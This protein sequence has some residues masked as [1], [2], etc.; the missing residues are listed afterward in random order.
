V[1]LR[2][3]DTVDEARALSGLLSDYVT[4]VTSEFEAATGVPVDPVGLIA[5]TLDSLETCVPPNGRTFVAEDDEGMILGMTFLRPSG[6]EGMEIKRLYV[7]PEARGTGAGRAL[8]EAAMA[9]T[10]EAGRS[11]MRLDT[12]RNLTGAV[13]LYTSLGFAFRE[14]YPESDHYGDEALLPYLVFME[15]RL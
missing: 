14:A 6:P 11:V 10:R 9:A 5:K 13:G 8:V 7:R 12:T 2:T 3:L 1:K 15:K 4:F